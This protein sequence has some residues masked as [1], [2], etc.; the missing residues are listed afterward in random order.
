MLQRRHFLSQKASMNKVENLYSPRGHGA[1]R[2]DI[3]FFVCRETA[4]NEKTLRGSVVKYSSEDTL[5]DL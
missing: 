1:H 5:P 2:D 3:I 4:A